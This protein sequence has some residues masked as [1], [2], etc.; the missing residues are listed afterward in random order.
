MTK[1]E[2]NY[3]QISDRC[4]KKEKQHIEAKNLEK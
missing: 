4:Q 1:W 2:H 3:I